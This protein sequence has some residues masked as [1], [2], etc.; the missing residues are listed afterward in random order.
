[1]K[2]WIDEKVDYLHSKIGGNFVLFEP[3]KEFY[4]K[5]EKI[6]IILPIEQVLKNIDEN[7]PPYVTFDDATKSLEK[8]L[9]RRIPKIE[10][11]PMGFGTNINGSY[12]AGKIQVRGESREI[13][14]SSDYKKKAKQLGTILAHELAHDFLFSIGTTLTNSDENEKLTDLASIMLGLGK[15]TLN[16]IEEKTD[17]GRK[18]LCYLSSS[19][20]AYAYVKVNSLYKVTPKA[21]F[22]NLDS[23]TYSLIENID[24][25]N[26]KSM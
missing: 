9:G 12:I 13:Q 17:S 23:A 11:Y 8:H 25:I 26:I 24:E 14:I 3:T 4:E 18:K 7:R 10:F 1:M 6:D 20:L 19:D 21:C 16:G 2:E 5:L 22:T 15:L